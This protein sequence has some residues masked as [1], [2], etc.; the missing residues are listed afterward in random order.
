MHLSVQQSRGLKGKVPGQP[1]EV[2]WKCLS[3]CVGLGGGQG[4]TKNK[5]KGE[6]VGLCFL[7]PCTQYSARLFGVTQKERD[8][9]WMSCLTSVSIS[10]SIIIPALKRKEMLYKKTCFES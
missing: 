2:F 4:S 3:R 9:D 1:P 8:C 10:S 7:I 6:E 5:E